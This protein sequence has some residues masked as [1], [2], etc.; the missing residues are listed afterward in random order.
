M[1]FAGKH[2]KVQ[3]EF[4]DDIR[5]DIHPNAVNGGQIEA[6]NR[7]RAWRKGSWPRL[8]MLL[9]LALEPGDGTSVSLLSAGCSVWM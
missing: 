3:T 9:A 6:R 1:V 8:E 2:G 4:A 7:Y 5:S